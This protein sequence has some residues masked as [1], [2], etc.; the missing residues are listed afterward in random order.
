MIWWHTSGDLAICVPGYAPAWA[1]QSQ[2]VMRRE[3]LEIRSQA[4]AAAVFAL[5]RA[6]R[7]VPGARGPADQLVNAATAVGAN[8]RATSRSRSRAEFVAN[9]RWLSTEPTR[10]ST[11]GVWAEDW[12]AP[13]RADRA[14]PARGQRTPCR[15]RRRVQDGPSQHPPQECTRIVRPRRPALIRRFAPRQGRLPDPQIPRSPDQITRSPHHEITRW[16]LSPSPGLATAPF[17]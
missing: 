4:L 15:T 7:T 5:C 3:D 13:R 8:Y 16:P 11:A 17:P 9:W 12:R 10:R 1:V 6:L 14:A 2:P